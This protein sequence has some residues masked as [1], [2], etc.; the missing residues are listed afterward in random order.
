[1]EQEKSILELMDE[2]LETATVE[3]FIE[4]CKEYGIE[5]EKIN[6]KEYEKKNLILMIFIFTTC[7]VALAQ[8]DNSTVTLTAEQYNA[9][10]NN[11]KESIEKENTYKT[12]GKWAGL[13]K[14]IGEGVN[15]N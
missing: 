13:G 12:L 15:G 5:L 7:F 1:M 14:E 4:D 3:S 6:E 8:N 9:L 2:W 11:V 10:P